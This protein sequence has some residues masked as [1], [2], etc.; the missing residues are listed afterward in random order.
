METAY[1]QE[2]IGK[3]DVA[4]NAINRKCLGELAHFLR[5]S[6][7]DI[8]QEFLLTCWEALS[9]GGGYDRSKGTLQGY[10]VGK[11]RTLLYRRD[12]F[13]TF[14]AM[15]S[16]VHEDAEPTE[17]DHAVQQ[18]TLELL[19]EC[20]EERQAHRAH[21]DESRLRSLVSPPQKAGWVQRLREQG[22]TQS[23][24][25]EIGGVSQAY[26]SRALKKSRPGTPP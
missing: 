14:N 4:F 17:A 10:F 8:R 18:S 5:W 1:E 11:L 19:I 2:F 21:R 23:Q 12:G 25:A 24:I 22:L 7:E 6:M 20:E 26:V 15:G 13:H 9:G 16:D 3:C